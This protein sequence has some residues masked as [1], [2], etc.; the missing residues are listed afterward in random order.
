ML[1]QAAAIFQHLFLSPVPCLL[2]P[3]WIRK[4]S[5]VGTHGAV[6]SGGEVSPRPHTFIHIGLIYVPS[7]SRIQ[8]HACTRGLPVPRPPA[9]SSPAAITL[10]HHKKGSLKWT[11]VPWLPWATETP[12]WS[13]HSVFCSLLRVPHK[14]HNSFLYMP[15]VFMPVFR[16]LSPHNAYIMFMLTMHGGKCFHLGAGFYCRAALAVKKAL[17][18]ETSV[19]A[20]HKPHLIW[21]EAKQW[22]SQAQSGPRFPI[23]FSS[24]KSILLML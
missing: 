13:F 16:E 18:V 8:T 12:L 24:L 5:S 9:L 23:H 3:S 1:A 4:Y 20:W 19:C 7:C 6:R 10:S 14:H 11:P 22:W 2:S 17:T 15:H 21:A